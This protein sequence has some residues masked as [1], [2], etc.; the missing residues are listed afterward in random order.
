MRPWTNTIVALLF[1][2][3]AGATGIGPCYNHA[4]PQHNIGNYCYC[5]RNGVCYFEGIHNSCD[6][7][8]NAIPGGCPKNMIRGGLRLRTEG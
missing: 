2:G 8:G 3:A 4:D 5:Q 7:P 6:P 1:M